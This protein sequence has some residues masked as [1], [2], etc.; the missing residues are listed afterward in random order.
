MLSVV[1]ISNNALSVIEYG[2]RNFDER[3]LECIQCYEDGIDDSTRNFNVCDTNKHETWK[4]NVMVTK[5]SV[6]LSDK[7][8]GDKHDN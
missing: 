4:V 7:I 2:C 8:F 6:E 5:P 3:D 1:L